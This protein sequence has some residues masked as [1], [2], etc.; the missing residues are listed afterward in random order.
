MTTIPSQQ[1]FPTLVDP[2]HRTISLLL[3]AM[4]TVAA[5]HAVVGLATQRRGYMIALA[6]TGYTLT[7]FLLNPVADANTPADLLR[8]LGTSN[9]LATASM[10]QAVLLAVTLYFIA[11]QATHATSRWPAV[12][13]GIVQVVPAVP[14]VLLMLLIEQLRLAELVGKRPE[15]VGWEIGLAIGGLVAIGSTLAMLLPP[16]WLREGYVWLGVGLLLT[17]MLLPAIPSPMPRPLWE[18]DTAAL[19][20]L[21]SI[22][23]I[24]GLVIGLGWYWRSVSTYLKHAVQALWPAHRAANSPLEN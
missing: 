23:L 6:F 17:C 13:L 5:I 22:L 4:A 16:R 20:A 14:V 8:W 3:M 18:I 1:W 21:A 10:L 15:T 11:R 9:G 12:G 2:N 7:G 19:V 24:A